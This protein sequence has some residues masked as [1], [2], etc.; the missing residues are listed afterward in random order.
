MGSAAGPGN[1]LHDRNASFAV[2]F[3][4]IF[5]AAGACGTRLLSFVSVAC[6]WGVRSLHYFFTAGLLN[7]TKVYVLAVTEHGTRLPLELFNGL[8]RSPRS[9]RPGPWCPTR[10]TSLPR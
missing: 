2:A 7:G 3:D 1:I 5:W 4:A 6:L 8:P 10:R 9:S